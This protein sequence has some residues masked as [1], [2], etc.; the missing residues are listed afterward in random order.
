[1]VVTLSSL[2]V[3]VSVSRVPFFSGSLHWREF[4]P[5]E[6]QLASLHYPGALRLADHPTTGESE[7]R[8]NAQT[9]RKTVFGGT[10]QFAMVSAAARRLAEPRRTGDQSAEDQTG[11]HP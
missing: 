10:S 9:D 4:H 3:R 8:Q 7:Q 1:M 6:H 5:L 11:V 2:A